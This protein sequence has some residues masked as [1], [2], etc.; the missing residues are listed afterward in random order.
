MISEVPLNDSHK[1]PDEPKKLEKLTRR[2]RR[3][4][5]GLRIACG[6]SW[7]TDRKTILRKVS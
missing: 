1:Q 3:R 2:Q 5:T 4:S 7:I 6:R